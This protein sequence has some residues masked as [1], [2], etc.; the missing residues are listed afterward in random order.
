MGQPQLVRV[1]K[2]E[3]CLASETYIIRS[4]MVAKSNWIESWLHNRRLNLEMG[5]FMV[6]ML[7]EMCLFLEELL[8]LFTIRCKH[9]I[10]VQKYGEDAKAGSGVRFSA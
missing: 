10:N 2:R 5:Y 9:A 1:E 4:G 7:R 8:R 6:F 3:T